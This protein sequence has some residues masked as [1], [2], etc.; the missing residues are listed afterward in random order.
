MMSLIILRR[1]AAVS[2]SGIGCSWC[3]IGWYCGIGWYWC[4]I[5]WYCGCCCWYCWYCTC[6][7]CGWYCTCGCCGWYCNCR[8]C[9]IVVSVISHFN[10]PLVELSTLDVV[11]ALLGKIQL[12]VDWEEVSPLGIELPFGVCECEE[13]DA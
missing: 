2:V 12:V 3:C 9:A 1:F 4:G 7:C 8:V 6:G 11:C 13:P 5:G 10:Q